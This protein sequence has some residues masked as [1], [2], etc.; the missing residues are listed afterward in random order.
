MDVK[1]IP[2]DDKKPMPIFPCLNC[3]RPIDF[4]IQG[5]PPLFC[6]DECR[7]EAE[8]IRHA[9]KMIGRRKALKTNILRAGKQWFAFIA[10]KK[11]IPGV[12]PKPYLDDL[13]RRIESQRP[14][15]A[16]DDEI[17]WHKTT[18][19]KILSERIRQCRATDEDIVLENGKKLKRKGVVKWFV[20]DEGHG[21]IK[22]DNGEEIVVHYAGINKKGFKTLL[23]GERVAFDMENGIKGPRAVAVTVIS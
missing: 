18:R 7:L 15:K 19:R 2:S 21:I 16:C 13:F 9:R 10:A 5:D 11:E 14:M 22:R 12:E 1:L 17:K 3:D 23:K 4:P 6:S 20:D 8:F